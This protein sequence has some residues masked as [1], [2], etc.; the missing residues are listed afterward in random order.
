[1]PLSFSKSTRA[2][3]V[4]PA[5]RVAPPAGSRILK[6]D[7]CPVMTVMTR[8][9][10]STCARKMER[11]LFL[12]RGWFTWCFYGAY[13]SRQME[14]HVGQD[15]PVFEQERCFQQERTLIVQDVLPPAGR[16]DFRQDLITKVDM[17][18]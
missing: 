2:V 3:M 18:G 8:G 13:S 10:V 12:N 11:R 17:Q 5:V 1:M 15:H 4:L 9:M 6:A 7:D 16:Q 14:R